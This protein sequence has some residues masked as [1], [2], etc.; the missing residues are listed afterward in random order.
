MKFH[1]KI[2]HMSSCH[3]DIPISPMRPSEF[4]DEAKAALQYLA[5][6]LHI[7]YDEAQIALRRFAPS[8]AN[9]W[10]VR[11]QLK[12]MCHP[13]SSP[14]TARL[15]AD[16]GI[17]VDYSTQGDLFWFRVKGCDHS[18]RL[19]TR[20]EKSPGIPES[21]VFRQE[22]LDVDGEEFGADT[23]LY[24][25]MHAPERD[26]EAVTLALASNKQSTWVYRGPGILD[27]VLVFDAGSAV[28][29]PL[30]RE[31]ESFFRDQM[32]RRPEQSAAEHSETYADEWETDDEQHGGENAGSA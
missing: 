28:V 11:T 25:M 23:R 30:P 8:R 10:V 27:E 29:A 9:K 15:L 16:H 26:L 12:D 2:S 20:P 13:L 24:L 31:D 32:A 17:K 22:A 6:V 1:V 18:I 3:L 21:G 19:V 7:A 5:G 14:D 4:T